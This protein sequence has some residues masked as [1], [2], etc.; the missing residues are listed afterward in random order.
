VHPLARAAAY[1]AA[2]PDER[3]AAHRALAAAPGDPDRRAWHLAA[4]AIGPDAEAA[5]AQEAA[6]RRARARSAYAAAAGSYERAARLTA[7]GPSRARRLFA[8]AESAWLGGHAD[9][10][11][12]LLDEA[13]AA[14]PDAALHLEIDHLRGH[15]ALRSGRVMEAHDVLSRAAATDPARAVVMLAEAADA[16]AYAA[17]PE[18][19]LQVARR[20]WAALRP[21]AGERDAFFAR[22]AL[23]MALIYNGRGEEGAGLVRDAVE[24]LERSDALSGDPRLL[25]SAALGPLWRATRRRAIAGR[26][27]RRSTRRRSAS[28][29]RP[30]RAPR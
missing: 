8:A 20:A 17:R 15:A 7:G 6:A 5:D 27:P 9:R 30:G 4:A 1:R 22:L 18:P 14:E 19:M 2:S 13:T 16:C 25:S 26:W 28:R 3:R 12:R 21:D 11:A 29:A 24:I 10:V 23:G